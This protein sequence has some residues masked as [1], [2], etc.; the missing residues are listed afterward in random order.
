M[1]EYVG[2]HANV[3][4]P[5]ETGKGKDEARIVSIDEHDSG[6][7]VKLENADS[8]YIRSWEDIEDAVHPEP[9]MTYS[10]SDETR[11]IG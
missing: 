6:W 8:T 10:D 2:Y 1:S 9:Q 4:F 5:T 11:H 3:T 7:L